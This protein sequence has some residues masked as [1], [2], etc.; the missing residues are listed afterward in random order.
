VANPSAAVLFRLA[1]ALHVDP[2]RLLAAAG[3]PELAN[4]HGGEGLETTIDP[5]LLAF[6]ARLSSGQ[7]QRLLHFL[8]SLERRA[9]ALVAHR[10]GRQVGPK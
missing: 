7:Q 8:R 3:Y 6:L 5:D 1:K 9:E 2:H 10:D 4:D